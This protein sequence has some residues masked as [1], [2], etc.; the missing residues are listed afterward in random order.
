MCRSVSSAMRSVSSA[1]VWEAA[2]KHGTGKLPLP[3]DFPGELDAA[4][5]EQLRVTFE[6]GLAA[7][8]LPLYHR[9]PFDR[10]LVAQAQLEGLTLVTADAEL[11]RYG[12]P[13]LPA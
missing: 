1:T 13:I 8:R 4:G 12:V 5:M 6:H 3:G 9:D 11:A 7:G 2:I 10:M